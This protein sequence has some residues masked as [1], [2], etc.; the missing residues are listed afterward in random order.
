MMRRILRHP[1][2]PATLSVVLAA[3]LLVLVLGQV[4]LLTR[5]IGELLPQSPPHSTIPGTVAAAPPEGDAQDSLPPLETEAPQVSAPPAQD[6]DA[7]PIQNR[8]G[9][10]AASAGS[11]SAS[12]PAPPAAESA[13]SAS[14]EPTP[15]AASTHEEASADPAPDTVATDVL[16]DTAATA[17]PLGGDWIAEGKALPRLQASWHLEDLLWLVDHDY[18]QI[19]AEAGNQ[20]FRI[21][22]D[23]ASLDRASAVLI[24]DTTD[25]AALARRGLAL[26]VRRVGT[27]LQ[28]TVLRARVRPL[29]K[30]VR[31]YA[32]AGEQPLL[33]FFP[34]RA[35][36]AYMQSKQLQAVQALE[37]KDR[38][39]SGLVTVGHVTIRGNRPLYIIDQVRAGEQTL[40][41]QD[42]EARPRRD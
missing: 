15:E 25:L 5:P 3:G 31:P 34:T 19:I 24:T 30:L 41:W 10:Q 20:S 39:L 7:V 32:P 35:F 9:G 21:L 23:G 12:R 27:H 28:P 16:P 6:M 33:S 18:G 11:E 4:T 36:D 42:P 2:I 17:L 14:A 40:P 26:N 38:D 1:A 13:P 37:L 22:L 29:E 8:P